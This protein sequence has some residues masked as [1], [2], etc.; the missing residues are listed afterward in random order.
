MRKAKLKQTP[1]KAEI[2][3]EPEKVQV[4][5]KAE[6]KPKHAKGPVTRPANYVFGPALPK[7]K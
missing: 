4:S 5:E 3:A 7:K 1:T 6:E 2:K